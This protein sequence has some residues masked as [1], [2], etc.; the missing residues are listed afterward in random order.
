MST[1]KRYGKADIH[2]HST[3][4]DGLSTPAEIV[5]Y[6][7]YHTNLDLIAITDHDTIDGGLEA[8]EL[9]ARRNYRVRVLPGIEISTRSGHILAL[10]VTRPVRTLQ[11][12]E[13]TIAAVHEQG[14]FVVVP[15]PMSWLTSS[16]DRRALE[17]ILQ[18]ARPEICIEGLETLNPSLAGRVVYNH[19][20]QLNRERYH[21]PETGGSDAHSLSLI[22][23]AYTRFEG[24][25]V[26]DFFRSLTALVCPYDR[27]VLGG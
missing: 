17:R 1:K 4:E 6:A 12:L 15:H 8:V 26:E 16:V 18:D 19:V 5:E 3:A 13:E 9:A 14:G 24:H 10:G 22:G 25:T 21:L 2:I 20:C 23:S 11:S 7:E 27:A